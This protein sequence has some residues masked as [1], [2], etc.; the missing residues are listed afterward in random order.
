MGIARRYNGEIV[1]ADSRTVYRGMD[2]GTAKPSLRD[3]QEVRHHL[4]DIVNPDQSFNAA[5]FKQLAHKAIADI[6]HRGRLPI[7]VGGT[8]LYINA[9]IFD[10]VFG[11]AA[12]LGLRKELED[13]SVVELQQICIQKNIEM[14]ANNLNKR[15]LVRAIEMNGI[16]QQKRVLTDDTFVVGITLEPAILQDRIKKRADTMFASG[17]VSEATTIAAAYGWEAEAMTGN[18]Y[19]VSRQVAENGMSIED[20]KQLVAQSDKKL[21]KK[22]LTWFRANPYVHWG[23]PD[24]LKSQIEHFL[25]KYNMRAV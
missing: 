22:Q 13:K 21:V 1:C 24:D 23:S 16:L 2:I 20:A 9:V 25:H 3:Q 19:R 18:I 5:L 11:D 4:L 8:G 12:D 17:V 10:Y 15:Y 7:L 14:P 6:R